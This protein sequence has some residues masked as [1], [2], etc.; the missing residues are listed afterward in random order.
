MNSSLELFSHQISNI[1]RLHVQQTFE[2]LEILTGIETRNK[3]QILDQNMGQFAFAAERSSG[4]LDGLLRMVFKHWRTFDIDVFNANRER[5][6][7]LHFPFRW[8]FKTLQVKSVE[9]EL[10]G[11]LEK[12]WSVFSKKFDVLDKHGQI[13]AKISS[14]FFKIWSFE[15]RF[16]PHKLGTLQKKWSGVLSEVFTDRDN[17]VVTYADPHL[18]AETKILMLSMS[19][20]VDIVYFENNNRS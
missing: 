9:G 7:M 11:L 15:F 3:Y 12:R 1:Q 2:G 16:G 5:V 18:K 20:L 6:L 17:F 4:L 10:I 19:L 14:P 13:V 8:Y